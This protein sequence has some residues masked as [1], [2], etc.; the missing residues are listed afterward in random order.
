VET[1]GPDWD[2][3]EAHQGAHMSLPRMLRD[4]APTWYRLRRH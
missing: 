2:L 4:A 3:E 1:F